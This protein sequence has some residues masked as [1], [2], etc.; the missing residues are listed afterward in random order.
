MT[1]EEVKKKLDRLEDARQEINNLYIERQNIEKEIIPFMIENKDKFKSFENED[2]IFK[3]TWV[4]DKYIDYEKMKKQY[5]DIYMLGLTR[6]FSKNV[7][8]KTV[9]NKTAAKILKDCTY[10]G[11]H[12]RVRDKKIWRRKVDG[13]KKSKD[14]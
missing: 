4:F 1:L 6:T 12:Y 10:D 7:L 2:Y 11:S 9:D 8:L 3:L 13:N 14:S 5:P